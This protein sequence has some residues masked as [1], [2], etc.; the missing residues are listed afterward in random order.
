MRRRRAALRPVERRHPRVRAGLGPSVGDLPIGNAHWQSPIVVDGRVAAAEGNAN[1][2]ATS[3]VLDIYRRRSSRSAGPAAA[4]LRA[5]PARAP[6]TRAPAATRSACG[7][8]CAITVSSSRASWRRLMRCSSS[9]TR[10]RRSSSASSW[11]SVS[12]AAPSL[13]AAESARRANA[14]ASSGPSVASSRSS[15]PGPGLERLD[16]PGG[17]ELRDGDPRELLGRVGEDAEPHALGLQPAQR[18]RRRRVRPQVD[19][20]VVLGEALEQRR[21]SSAARSSS[22]LGVDVRAARDVLEPGV[23]ERPR[24]AEHAVEVDRERRV[25]ACARIGYRPRS[26]RPAST[27]RTSAP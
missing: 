23:P 8:S 14:R 24:V 27:T 20:R 25:I 10:S 15:E 9:T 4:D 19:G 16:P 11:R 1:D 12:S 2:H 6:R 3:G 13:E 26:A 7:S 21:A 18:R 17:A 5:L 22:R